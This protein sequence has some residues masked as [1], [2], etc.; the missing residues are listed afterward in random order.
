MFSSK[1]HEQT[2]IEISQGDYVS[3]TANSF[4]MD[5]QARELSKHTLRFYREFL[6]TFI[7]YCNVNSLRFIQE[8]TP[9]FLRR[10][11]LAF[12]E[13]H[14][15]GG[16]HAAYRTLRAFLHWLVREEVM[17][18]E[19]KGGRDGTIPI[20]LHFCTHGVQPSNYHST[21]RS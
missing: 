3:A 1:I 9:D 20:W 8:I 17:A 14:N 7:E 2:I 13:K 4:L 19:W 10:Y 15:P 11:F 21:I 6:R 5:R 16:V 18:P 12:S